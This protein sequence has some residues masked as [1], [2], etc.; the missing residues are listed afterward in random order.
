[1]A[2][3]Q[4]SD[5]AGHLGLDDGRRISLDC[6]RSAVSVLQT[7]LPM[8]TLKSGRAR[9]TDVASE[10]GV[11]LLDEAGPDPSVWYGFTR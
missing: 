7:A 3:W 9:S 1:M 4:R 11:D 5:I 8:P 2:R 6:T 10:L